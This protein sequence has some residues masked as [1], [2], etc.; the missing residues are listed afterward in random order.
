MDLDLIIE[1]QVNKKAEQI[2]I[3]LNRNKK[4]LLKKIKLIM[5]ILIAYKKT[6][7]NKIDK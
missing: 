2:K 4:I 3:I 5:M 7:I 1:I 6:W